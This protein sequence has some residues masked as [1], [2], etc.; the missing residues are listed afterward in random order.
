M[1][2]TVSRRGVRGAKRLDVNQM[3]DV[4]SKSQMVTSLGV[5]RQFSGEDSHYEINTENGDRE[6]LVDVELIPSGTRVQCRL[7]FGNDGMYRI[8]RVD[9]EVAVLIPYDPQSL[10]KDSLDFG[11]IIVGVMDNDAPSELTDDDVIIIKAGKVIIESADTKVGSDS[12]TEAMV[13]GNAY[14]TAEDT[15]LTALNTA[16]LAVSAYAIAVAALPAP[17]PATAGAQATLTT[18]VAAFTTAKSTFNAAASTYLATKGK[19][20]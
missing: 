7:G 20:E 18:A 13:L 16:L 10:I 12:A 9:T 17:F 19:V 5:V 14:R 2:S 3:R 4:F 6:I 1:R 8:P 15:L 11:P